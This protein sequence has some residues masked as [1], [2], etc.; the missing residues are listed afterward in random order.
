MEAALR[1]R[2]SIW[3]RMVMAGIGLFAASAVAQ[4]VQWMLDARRDQ[5]WFALGA[6]AAGLLI[7]LAGVGALVTEWRHLYQLR[8][9]AEE[10]DTG[11]E[12]LHSHGIGRGKAFCEKLARQA[13]WIRGT[14]RY[15]AGRRPCMRRT[16]IA[17]WSRSMPNWFSRYSIV[18]RAP[19]SAAT[20]PKRR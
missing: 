14:R 10:R 7:V 6:G 8:Q 5:A 9:R 12:L 11:R 1:P 3:R 17:K 19:K 2:R 13:G 15:S 4:G 20:P 16:T 18:R